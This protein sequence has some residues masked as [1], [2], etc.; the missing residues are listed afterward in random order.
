MRSVRRIMKFLIV[1]KRFVS[2]ESKRAASKMEVMRKPLSVKKM[3]TPVA[4]S[5]TSR[6]IRKTPIG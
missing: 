4:P 3:K 6:R 2:L 5:G 1:T